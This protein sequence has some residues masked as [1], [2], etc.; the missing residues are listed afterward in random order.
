MPEV[1]P[2]LM[3]VSLA[4]AGL[5]ASS[6]EAR[7]TER[8]KKLDRG[9][10]SIEVDL[11]TH[12]GQG[13]GVLRT[14]DDDTVHTTGPGL[15]VGL[16]VGARR[17][18]HA[19]IGVSALYE[20]F[21]RAEHWYPGDDG[22]RWARSLRLGL[23]VVF[24]PSPF[25]TTSPYL[26]AGV[27]YRVLWVP[28]TDTSVATQHGPQFLRLGGGFD[29]IAADGFAIGPWASADLGLTTWDNGGAIESGVTVFI[30]S[31]I[32]FVFNVEGM[33]HGGARQT[34]QR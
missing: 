1:T 32:H 17:S 13:L 14:T 7:G 31:G 33:R 29:V 27:G 23:D 20:M 3:I 9:A 21:S 16:M 26:S 15:G 8:E 4:F 25:A 6:T 5:A 12:F 22:D 19:L 34:G 2:K 30:Q 18:P 11:A 10:D 24:H 28:A